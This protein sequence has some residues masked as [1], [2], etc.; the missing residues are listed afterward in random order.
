MTFATLIWPTFFRKIGSD[1]NIIQETLL[2]LATPSGPKGTPL[3]GPYLVLTLRMLR[4]TKLSGFICRHPIVALR[5]ADKIVAGVGNFCAWGQRFTTAFIL[6]L[7][8]A[9]LSYHMFYDLA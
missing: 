1:A 5:Y 7:H 6:K 9:T 2:G 4:T 8:S 3:L